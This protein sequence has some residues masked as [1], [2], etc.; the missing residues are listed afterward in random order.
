MSGWNASRPVGR[1]IEGV[2]EGSATVVAVVG[3]FVK[4]KRL[5]DDPE[6][7]SNGLFYPLAAGAMWLLQRTSLV[8]I[9]KNV[10]CKI[11]KK[12]RAERRATANLAIDV[13]IILKFAYVVAAWRLGWNEPL[14]VVFIAYLLITNST[15]YFFYN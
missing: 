10:T 1:A 7:T 3:D 4:K 14:P 6:W 12:A 13:F 15:T 9:F 2:S 8:E 5:R 11:A